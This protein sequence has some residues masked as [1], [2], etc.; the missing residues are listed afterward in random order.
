MSAVRPN[1]SVCMSPM[2]ASIDKWLIDGMWPSTIR[3]AMKQRQS[4]NKDLHI[5]SGNIL[6]VHRRECLG[7][8][9]EDTENTQLQKRE[10]QYIPPEDVTVDVPNATRPPPAP[11]PVPTADVFD[12]PAPTPE[13]VSAAMRQ[14]LLWQIKFEP[15]T[16]KQLYDLVLADMKMRTAE[17]EAAAKAKGAEKA[18]EGGGDE[19]FENELG[20]AIGAASSGSP[21]RRVK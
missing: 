6:T 16:S 12:G 7:I 11:P 13:Q 8:I 21:L 20:E 4:R 14:R 3:K 10:P 15:L 18:R 17:A 1:C 5:P 19:E 9:R 2:I